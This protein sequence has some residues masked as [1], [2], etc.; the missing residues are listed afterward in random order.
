MA[1]AFFKNK[2]NSMAKQAKKV[3]KNKKVKILLPIAGR[4]L[5]SANVG[6]VVSYP[7]TL[8]TELVEDKFAEFVK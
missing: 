4:Y 5:L 3:D 6:D 7:E 2:S 1:K 8:A